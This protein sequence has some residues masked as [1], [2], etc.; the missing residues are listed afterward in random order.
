MRDGCERRKGRCMAV[1]L[2]AAG[3]RQYFAFS[4]GHL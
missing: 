4:V 3:R 2:L 1:V